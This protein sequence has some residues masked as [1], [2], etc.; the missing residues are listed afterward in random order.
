M[1]LL[2]DSFASGFGLFLTVLTVSTDIFMVFHVICSAKVT[3]LVFSHKTPR[4]GA[5]AK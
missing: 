5:S 4:T 1:A 2:K 3:N